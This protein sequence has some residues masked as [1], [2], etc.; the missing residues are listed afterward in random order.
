M[1]RPVVFLDR[2]GVIIENR[3][4]YVKSWQEVHFLPGVFEV[5]R[6][7]GQSEYSLVLVTNQSVVG[8][9]I[10]ALDEV[11][12]IN[13]QVLAEIKARGG[14]IDA[15]YLCPHRAD[16]R[17][18]CRK[19]EPGML[20]KAATELELDLE[21]SYMVG[22]AVTDIKAASAAG[23]RGI[24]V[25]TGRGRDQMALLAAEEVDCLVMADL[26]AAANYILAQRGGGT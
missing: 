8:Q 3:S 21:R 20:L 13:E 7:L 1:A 24:L 4:D 2:D 23:V 5:L 6:R 11:I 17:C 16:E 9:G 22:D 14:R 25:L 15:S 19:P 18:D 10:T 12:Q 26:E